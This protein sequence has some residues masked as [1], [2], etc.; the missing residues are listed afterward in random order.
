MDAIEINKMI[1]NNE[2]HTRTYRMI[3]NKQKMCCASTNQY[4]DNMSQNVLAVECRNLVSN[5]S[6]LIR[7]IKNYFQLFTESDCV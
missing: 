1:R 7:L 2:K 6:F 4:R 5:A 3:K